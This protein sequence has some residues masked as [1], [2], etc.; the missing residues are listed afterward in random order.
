M[1]LIFI[2]IGAFSATLIG[3]LFAIY[4]NDR[5]HLVL[6]FSAG[7]VIGVAFF[8]L[9]PEAL[10]LSSGKFATS[11]ITS[12]VALGFILYML[13][14]R[15]AGFHSHSHTDDQAINNHEHKNFTQLMF[16]TILFWQLCYRN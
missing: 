5:R 4:L 7:A 3:G 15:L 9:L 8:D 12:L 6:G 1:M 16:C 13:L 10:E 14:D 2:A 11:T